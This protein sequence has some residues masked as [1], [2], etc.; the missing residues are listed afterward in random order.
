MADAIRTNEVSV[1]KIALAEKEKR[2]QEEIYKD[3]EGSKT[4]KVFLVIGGII[5]IIA[6]IIGVYFL[7]QNKKTQDAN[8]PLVMTNIDTFLSY[9]SK[10]YIDTTN[11]V[12]INDLLGVI[13]QGSI[14]N[15]QGLIN[16]LFLTKMVNKIPEIITSKNFLS[17]IQSTAPESLTRSLADKFLLGKYTNPGATSERSKSGTFLILETTD[18]ALAYASMINWENTMLKDLFVLFKIKVTGTEDPLFEK[19]WK[20]I[21][22]NNRDVRV[23]YGEDGT[24]ILYYVFINKNDLVITDNVEAL[25]E[26]TGRLIIK[27]TQPL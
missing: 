4:S 10:S 20:D 15:T 21:I 3:A 19:Q 25:K 16:A 11:V 5:F 22:I 27:N 12:S 18:Y 13:N 2:E 1:I 8:K 23:L 17:L 6:A 7:Y 24:G 14:G 9:D 26:V